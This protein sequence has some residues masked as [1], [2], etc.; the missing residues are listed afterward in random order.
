MTLAEN[1]HLSQ[2]DWL[3][4]R[5]QVDSEGIGTGILTRRPGWKASDHQWRR[6]SC[7]SGSA[8]LAP[9]SSR[10]SIP[11]AHRAEVQHALDMILSI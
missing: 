3:R 11:T 9:S 2:V 10:C 6:V 7:I 5:V 4:P 8:S 1:L